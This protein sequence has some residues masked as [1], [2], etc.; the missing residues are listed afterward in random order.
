MPPT[1]CTSTTTVLRLSLSSLKLL[2][3]LLRY[4]EE[5]QCR[6][7]VV[8]FEKSHLFGGLNMVLVAIVV[9]C[10]RVASRGD[11]KYN[12]NVAGML[13]IR[14]KSWQRS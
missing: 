2:T 7:Y 14:Q 12:Y 13:I 4:S 5:L 8:T 10:K 9:C 11:G 6:G 1:L 3:C